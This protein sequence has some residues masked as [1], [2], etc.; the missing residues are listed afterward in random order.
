MLPKLVS[1][2]LNNSICNKNW[3][4]SCHSCV[5]IPTSGGELASISMLHTHNCGNSSPF[6][7]QKSY[8]ICETLIFKPLWVAS[9]VNF[10]LS[11]PQV[12]KS[13]IQKLK[14]RY[15]KICPYFFIHALWFLRVPDTKPVLEHKGFFSVFEY[16]SPLFFRKSSTCS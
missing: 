10:G 6:F 11:R 1:H 2:I 12:S 8:S 13:C 4:R 3:E 15:V 7:C 16:S 5:C 9:F 14:F